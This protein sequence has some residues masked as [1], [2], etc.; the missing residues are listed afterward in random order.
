M[1]FPRLRRT[2]AGP[3]PAVVALVVTLL[4]LAALP[5]V[6][7]SA[8]AQDSPPPSTCEEVYGATTRGGAQLGQGS[9]ANGM[10]CNAAPARR[11]DLVLVERVIDGDT[12][13]IAGGERVRYI[14]IDTPELRPQAEPFASQAEA[15][16]R[17][18]VQGRY[19]RLL[20]GV[21][22]RDRLVACCA[23]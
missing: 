8:L 23:T 1:P 21:T 12:I 13:E 3:R 16:N 19:V 5:G 2:V 6:P 4:A 22:D 17:R 15:M 7:H 9:R 18:L 10:G 14:G 11:G 20:S